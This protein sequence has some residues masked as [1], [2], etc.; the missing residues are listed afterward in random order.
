[1]R[2]ASGR[3]MVHHWIM[4]ENETPRAITLRL[5][6]ELAEKVQA[7]ADREHRSQNSMVT[8]LVTE[9]LDARARKDNTR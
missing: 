4:A 1:M 9:A 3:C 5:P 7:S 8:I 6:P 2:V